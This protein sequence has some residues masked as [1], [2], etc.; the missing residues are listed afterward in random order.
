ME[1]VVVT[2][3]SKK[4][5]IGFK[6]NQ[7]ALGKLVSLL[8]GEEPKKI[9][10][11]LK[12]V[13][14]SV[15]GGEI[16]G[17]IGLNGSGKSTLLRVIAGIYKADEGIVSTTGHV[18]S[19]IGLDGGLKDRLTLRDNIYLLCYFYGL[20]RKL[21]NK[22]LNSII[23]FAELE[24]FTNTKI[25]QLSD[26]MKQRLAF[27]IAIHCN[28]DILILDEV[29]AVG[30]ESFK[31]K[32]VKKI[33]ELVNGGATV[34]LVTHYLGIIEK[35]IGRHCDKVI[36]MDSGSIVTSGESKSIMTKYIKSQ[37]LRKKLL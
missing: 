14:F 10:W 20:D 13:S 16:I 2:N 31:I 35:Y 24:N 37:N 34:L 27:S 28:P 11:G 33:K 15:N 3:V 22:R 26:G 36:W 8:S 18:I 7:G 30:D 9:I 1:R 17:I 21:I 4:F 19:L 5:H 12:N 29:F 25:Y 23:E 6:K 32:S